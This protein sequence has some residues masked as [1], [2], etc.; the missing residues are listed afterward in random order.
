MFD[1]FQGLPVHA[2]IVHAT[3]V[4]LPLMALVTVVVAVRPR[5]RARFAWWAVAVDAVLV[6]LTFA[7][8]QS[9]EQLQQRLGSGPALDRHAHLGAQLIWFVLALAVTALLVALVKDRGGAP[10]AGAS[11]LTAVAAVLLLV[12]VVRVGHTGAEAVWGGLPG[13]RS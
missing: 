3:V 2:L 12:W 5:L 10:S 7:T 11:V 8:K 13:K 4:L 1:T 9:G 6:P